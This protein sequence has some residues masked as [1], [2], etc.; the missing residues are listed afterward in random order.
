MKRLNRTNLIA[1]VVSTAL[2]MGVITGCGSSDKTADSKTTGAAQ[3]SSTTENSTTPKKNITLTVAASQDWIVD[4]DKTLAEKF[5]EETG[6]KIDQQLNPSDQYTNIV[7]AKLASGEGPDIFYCNGAIGM[8]EYLPEKYFAD[9]SNE[10]WVSGMVDWAKQAA[11][12]KGKTVGLDMWSVDGWGM[13]YNDKIFEKY[14]LQVPKTFEEFL[15]VCETLKTNGIIPVYESGKDTWHQCIWLLSIGDYVN[16]KYP[17]LYDKLNTKEG[18]FSDIP[19]ALLLTEQLKQIV[20]K[21]YFGKNFMSQTWDARMDAMVS[22]KFGMILTYTAQTAEIMDKYPNSG[23]DSWRMFPVPLAGNN[24]FSTSGG[25]EIMV[26]NKNSKYIEEA[27]KYFNFLTKPENL[28]TYY[29]N[30]KKLV[31]AAFG[32]VK[33]HEPISWTSMIENSSGGSGIDFAAATPFF[34]ADNIGKAY[35]DLYIG[36]KTPQQVLE[37][38]D[39]D[40]DKMFKATSS[41]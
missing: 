12:Y 3:T 6:I 29:D 25:G 34:N 13:L 26:I 27:K 7:K 17:G 21:G 37:R 39:L 9:L 41:N 1:C 14:N 20:D 23:A 24:S 16:K 30:K 36:S 38:V 10:S 40:R 5:T 22:G 31:T 8:N 32:S 28:Q 2:L 4:I 19:E 18:K 15:T 35:Q 11:S 33:M